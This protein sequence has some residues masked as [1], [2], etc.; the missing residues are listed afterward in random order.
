LPSRRRAGRHRG[1]HG[2]GQASS[3]PSRV[4]LLS[5]WCLWGSGE[6]VG[7]IPPH[8]ELIVGEFTVGGQRGTVAREREKRERARA[9]RPGLLGWTEGA[10]RARERE[11]GVRERAGRMRSA[12]PSDR[13][14]E[15]KRPELVFLVFL[16]PKI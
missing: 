3:G 13:R 16:F 4:R 6:V 14:K 15:E 5:W 8:W 7:A 1:R 11:R 2:R 9:G 12:G 10:G